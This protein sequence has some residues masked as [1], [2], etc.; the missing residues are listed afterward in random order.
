MKNASILALLV[1][2]SW[3]TAKTAAASSDPPCGGGNVGS[4]LCEDPSQCCSEWGYCGNSADHCNPTT[5]WSGPGCPQRGASCGNGIIGTGLC[6]DSSLCCSQFGYC[7]SDAEYCDASTCWS[8]PNCPR[9][10]TPC[11][12]GTVGTG[13]CDDVTLC[14]SQ[15]GY[16]D[17]TAEHCDVTTCYSSPDNSCT[18]DAAVTRGDGGASPT[19]P[20][21]S[22]TPPPSLPTTTTSPPPTWSSPPAAVSDEVVVT[23]S[24]FLVDIEPLVQDIL[25]A[26]DADPTNP[27]LQDQLRELSIRTWSSEAGLQL[28]QSLDSSDT[29]DDAYVQLRDS[30]LAAVP[31]LCERIESGTTRFSTVAADCLC[32]RTSNPTTY[33]AAVAGR[34]ILDFVAGGGTGNVRRGRHRHHRR[35]S[36]RNLLGCKAETDE[37]SSTF[38]DLKKI[39]DLITEGGGEEFCLEAECDIPLPAPVS[40]I[41]AQLGAGGCFPGIN[42]EDMTICTDG[43]CNP[44]ADMFQNAVVDVATDTRAFVTASLCLTGLDDVPFIGDVILPALD[45]L[46]IS[47]CFA[48]LD[49]TF[50]PLMGYLG[51]GASV[52][53]GLVSLGVD[54]EAQFYDDVKDT[55]GVC[56]LLDGDQCSNQSDSERGQNSC[57]LCEGQDRG[58]FY[59]EVGFWIFKKTFDIAWG[60]AVNGEC[61]DSCSDRLD[62][63]LL[64]DNPSTPTRLVVYATSWAQY[65]VGGATSLPDGSSVTRPDSCTPR[66]TKPVDA[67][68]SGATHINYAFAVLDPVS[69]A[70]IEY[71]WNDAQLMDSLNAGKGDIKTLISIGGWSFSQGETPTFGTSSK[72]VF[73]TMAA[74][75]ASRS[76]FISSAIAFATLHN[77]DGIDLDWE[78][79]EE[80]DRE[81]FIALLAEMRAAI[82]GDGR[83]MLFTAALP[84]G[85]T[86]FNQIAIERVANYLDFVNLMA[87]DFHGGS[88][89]PNGP[90]FS[91]TP[92][93]DCSGAFGDGW[94]IQTA[95]AAYLK[96]GVPAEKL[97]LGLGTYG[98]T[99]TLAGSDAGLGASANG[100]GPPGPCT[101]EPGS[102]AYYE[103]AE[104]IVGEVSHDGPTLSAFAKYG[105]NG[106]V[107]FDDPRSISDKVCWARS[108]GLGGLMVWDADQDD[109]STLISGVKN[110]MGAD[111]SESCGG[112]SMPSCN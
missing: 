65:R 31:L 53:M 30:A 54:V 102:L 103:I 46:G 41:E 8:G 6:D 79:P 73:P 17:T 75:Q 5:C 14:C 59:V 92:I 78:Y 40:F 74:S 20:G 37:G 38:E 111:F 33:C 35:E 12:D 44:I 15:Y 19:Y 105:E 60:D 10:G 58:K 13:L 97:S 83:G 34:E 42:R 11:G 55:F 67:L 80:A 76:A 24:K 48:D 81:N 62:P 23:T 22:P 70:V 26:L 71:E 50:W 63:G 107:V 101:L 39:Y 93:L 87:Y 68:A 106:F 96:A 64:P 69:Y 9:S 99:W 43:T 49:L 51:F 32:G 21:P 18:R 108:L 47:T 91:H 29:V 56:G 89:E 52:H 85:S 94:D 7:G 112:F 25:N 1:A 3:G 4:G 110:S 109:G 72:T 86:N 82:D 27:N 36:E 95:V 57:S 66:A 100:A 77:F 98:R 2:I 104:S 84:A 90:M 61:I 45:M 28:A 16:C 88:F